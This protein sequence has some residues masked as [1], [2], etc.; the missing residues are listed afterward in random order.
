VALVLGLVMLGNAAWGA[1]LARG[2]SSSAPPEAGKVPITIIGF[3]SLLSETSAR[4]T[5]PRLQNFRLG[6]VRGFRRVFRHPAAIF[7]ERGIARPETK[8]ISSLS[9]EPVDD[10]TSG[11]TVCVFDVSPDHLAMDEFYRREEEFDVRECSFTDLDSQEEGT[12]LMCLASTDDAFIQQWGRELFEEKYLAQGIETIWGWGPESGILPC[13][14]YLRHCVLAVSKDGVDQRAQDSFFDETFL[15]DRQTTVRQYLE[16]NTHVM[17]SVPP[18][19]L[20]GRY[21]G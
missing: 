17:E 11:F 5:F 6:R 19:N 2:V 7:F 16:A 18:E 15:A 4:T 8:E 9:A 10:P 20:V 14:V 12:G 13:P 21:S 1:Y 3:G